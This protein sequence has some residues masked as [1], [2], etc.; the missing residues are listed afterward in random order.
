MRKTFQQ[1]IAMMEQT[2]STKNLQWYPLANK[3]EDSHCVGLSSLWVVCFVPICIGA[4][5]CNKVVGCFAPSAAFDERC[6]LQTWR[7]LTEQNS[8]VLLTDF[9]EL[10]E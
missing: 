3:K 5:N 4:I 9:A 2:L 10:F 7:L 6:L 8:V 1:K